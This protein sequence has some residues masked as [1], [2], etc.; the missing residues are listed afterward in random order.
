VVVVVVNE[1]DVTI[2]ELIGVDVVV[3]EELV[4]DVVSSVGL[5]STSK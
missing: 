5:V 3:V 2:D 4:E 1:F